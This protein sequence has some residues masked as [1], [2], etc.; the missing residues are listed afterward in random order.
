MNGPEKTVVWAD[1]PLPQ[2]PYPAYD[3]V[4]LGLGGGI[5]TTEFFV[6][7]VHYTKSIFE[8]KQPM[9]EGVK[10]GR[11][12]DLLPQ[13]ATTI[14]A[15]NADAAKN[16]KGGGSEAVDRA[17]LHPIKVLGSFLNVPI[18][19]FLLGLCGSIRTASEAVYKDRRKGINKITKGRKHFLHKTAKEI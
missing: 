7:V 4:S 13:T 1:M 9:S 3:F 16:L 6:P 10:G 11:A 2:N 17:F 18:L 19:H 14:K 8:E 5:E 12:I 15:R